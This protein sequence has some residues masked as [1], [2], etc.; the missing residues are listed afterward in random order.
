MRHRSA[1]PR[2]L[3]AHLGGV[4][5]LLALL[6]QLGASGMALPRMAAAHFDAE[7]Q[8]TICHADFSGM[9]TPT[10]THDRGADCAL[11]P[12][13]L[14][15]SSGHALLATPAHVLSPPLLL[16][17]G[18]VFAAVAQIFAPGVALRATARGPPSLS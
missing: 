15:L 10:P 14:A 16:A 11:C 3:A 8:T 13:C 6:V 2:R 9:Q 12:L 18:A 4:L 7:L 5:A 1:L 17:F